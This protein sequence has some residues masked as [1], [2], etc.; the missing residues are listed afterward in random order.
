MA[1]AQ[2]RISAMVKSRATG[3]LLDCN[4]S[5]MPQCTGPPVVIGERSPAMVYRSALHSPAW[6]A[7][8]AP[9]IERR[10]LAMRWCNHCEVGK[11]RA[12][13][14]AASCIGH[15]MVQPLRVFHRLDYASV[16]FGGRFSRKAVIPSCASC[17]WDAPA[18]AAMATE[19]ASTTGRSSCR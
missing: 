18:I 10:A 12:G 2:P 9:S 6:F 14:D 5:L 17:V 16:H 4:Q 8:P 15:A 3:I 13:R 19:Y 11:A 7:C 1:R